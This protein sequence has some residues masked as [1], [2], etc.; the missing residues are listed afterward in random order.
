[1]CS[2]EKNWQN[3]KIASRKAQLKHIFIAKRKLFDKLVQKSKCSYWYKIQTDILNKAKHDNT[4]SWKHIGKVG[5][6][7]IR[8]IP[9]KVV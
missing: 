1:M 3:C 4:E 6:S 5:I 7:G 9:T 2:H 8:R